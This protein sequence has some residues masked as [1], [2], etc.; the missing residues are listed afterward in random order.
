ML[1]DRETQRLAT[2]RAAPLDELL[3]VLLRQFRRLLLAHGLPLSDADAAIIAAALARQDRSDPRMDRLRL[4][5]VALVEESEGVLAGM[6]LTFAQS[7]RADMADLQG[8][9]ST[10]DFLE[11]AE[12]KANAELRISA[13]SSLLVLLGERRFGEYLQAVLDRAAETGQP[14]LDSVIAERVLQAVSE[15]KKD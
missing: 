15:P 11:L 12:Q 5:L 13:G 2:Y 4:G 14:D 3:A 6:G 1:P 9:E 8:W 10:A 7:L